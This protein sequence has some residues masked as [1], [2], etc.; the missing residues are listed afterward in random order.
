[1]QWEPTNR[2]NVNV[3]NDTTDFYRF[4][5]ATVQAEFLYDCVRQTIE[6][7]LPEETSFLQLH[8]EFRIRIES[9]IDMPEN[10]LNLLFRFLRQNHGRLSKRAKEKEFASCQTR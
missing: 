5:D 10:T 2:G 6:K 7:E 8:D 1:M 3:F 9:I 4:F